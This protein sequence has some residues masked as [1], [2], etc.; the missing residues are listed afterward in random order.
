MNK[1]ASLIE[2]V[3]GNVQQYQVDVDP[4]RLRTYDLPLA[5][6]RPIM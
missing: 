2:S 5:V 3:G 1:Y 4:N 6:G